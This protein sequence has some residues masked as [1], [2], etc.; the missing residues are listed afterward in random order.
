MVAK[1]G[2]LYLLIGQDAPSKDVKINKIK[3]SFLSKNLEHFNLDTLYGRELALKFFQEKAVLLPVQAKKRIIIIR[4]AQAMK[5]D[6]KKF[7]LENLATILSKIILILDIGRF[8]SKDDFLRKISAQALVYRFGEQVQADAFTLSRQI[9][10]KKTDYALKTLSK[11]LE[12][13]ERPERILGGLRFAWERRSGSSAGI[14]KRLK[15]LLNC[16]IDIK[17]GKLKPEFALE[18]L[19]VS[20]CALMKARA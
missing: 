6:I 2:S 9:E 13:G 16:D 1:D 4:Q 8:D 12:N 18:K 20:L 19:V 14:T 11:L 3:E 5:D 17:T 7:I 10:F 15:L